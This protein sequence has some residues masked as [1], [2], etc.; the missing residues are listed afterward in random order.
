[1]LLLHL[2]AGYIAI[3][4]CW[5]SLCALVKNSWLHSHWDFLGRDAHKHNC[6]V[7]ALFIVFSHFSIR[8]CKRSF[9]LPYRTETTNWVN[10]R[11]ALGRKL[12]S[13]SHSVCL[14]KTMYYAI[15]KLKWCLYSHLSEFGLVA[16]ALKLFPECGHLP[17]DSQSHKIPAA[18]AIITYMGKN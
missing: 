6:S 4:Q 5:L 10:W 15:F 11:P 2:P 17:S 9:L 16:E 14:F 18:T 1:M 3:C 12:Y 8:K 13:H 7:L